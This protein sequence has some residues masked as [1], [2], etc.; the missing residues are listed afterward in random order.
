VSRRTSIRPWRR[1]DHG[2]PVSERGTNLSISSF[3]FLENLNKSEGLFVQFSLPFWRLIRLLAWV[4]SDPRP[5][6]AQ[7]LSRWDVRVA[8]PST[9][10][11]PPQDQQ[12]TVRRHWESTSRLSHSTMGHVAPRG[13]G[14]LCPRIGIAYRHSKYRSINQNHAA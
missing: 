14:R 1:S 8:A 2:E 5:P 7:G 9:A 10:W 11:S 3:D 6:A 4:E 13:D 12:F